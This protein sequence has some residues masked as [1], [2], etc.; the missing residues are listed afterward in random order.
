MCFSFGFY[1]FGKRIISKFIF[2]M[3]AF[4]GCLLL[5]IEFVSLIKGT[6]KKNYETLIFECL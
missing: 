6:D 4:F 5:K 3:L 1:N 2:S